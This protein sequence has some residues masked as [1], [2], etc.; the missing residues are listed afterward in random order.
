MIKWALVQSIFCFLLT[1]LE[2]KNSLGQHQRLAE[3]LRSSNNGLRVP[4]LI[5]DHEQRTFDRATAQLIARQ[6]LWN[7]IEII[8][9]L[10]LT[11][12]IPN[13]LYANPDSNWKKISILCRLYLNSTFQALLCYLLKCRLMLLEGFTEWQWHMFICSHNNKL[14][15]WILRQIYWRNFCRQGINR[16]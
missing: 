15:R 14:S 11:F 12:G 13:L 16:L 4:K 5:P 8:E 7:L 6:R 2:E 3:Q 10:R 1:I 9:F